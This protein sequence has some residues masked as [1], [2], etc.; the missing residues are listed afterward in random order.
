[1]SRIRCCHTVIDF[2]NTEGDGMK[3]ILQIGV[4]VIGILASAAGAKAQWGDAAA[5]FAIGLLLCAAVLV[6]RVRGARN[7]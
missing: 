6:E 2:G 5:V 3:N 7:K 4:Y 1:M